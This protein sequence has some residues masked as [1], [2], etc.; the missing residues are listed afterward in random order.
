[1]TNDIY[2][3]NCASS[4]RDLLREIGISRDRCHHGTGSETLYLLFLTW[5][6][7]LVVMAPRPSTNYTALKEK[8]TND[9]G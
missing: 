7:I 3:G 1:M 6:E 4:S 5:S 8:E 9:S 2:M